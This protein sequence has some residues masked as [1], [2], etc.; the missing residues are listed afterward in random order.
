[1]EKT[2]KLLEYSEHGYRRLFS[3]YVDSITELNKDIVLPQPFFSCLLACDATDLPDELIISVAHNFL[4]AGVAA[5]CAWGPDCDRVETMFDL[6]HV[7]RRLNDEKDYE[8][9]TTS[10]KGDTLDEA[11]WFLLN[12]AWPAETDL[13][14]PLVI[15]VGN[16]EW[17]K[18]VQDRLSN[19]E[20]LNEIV[21]GKE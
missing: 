17:D 3:L 13:S 12:C 10:H 21:V 16:T 19:L 4:V 14:S 20:K 1:M 11:I 5:Q 6:A 8:L 18:Q 2:V 9:L 15:T 7:Y